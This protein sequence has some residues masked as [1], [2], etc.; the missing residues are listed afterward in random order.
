MISDITKFGEAGNID[1]NGQSVLEFV[2]NELAKEIN[3]DGTKKSRE[4]I[5]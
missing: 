3:E 1:N 4:T 5:S 2:I